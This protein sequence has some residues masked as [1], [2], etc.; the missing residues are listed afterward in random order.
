[1]ARIQSLKSW[2]Q[3]FIGGVSLSQGGGGFQTPEALRWLGRRPP[4]ALTPCPLSRPPHPP[5]RERGSRLERSGCS[6]L[7]S[8]MSLLAFL[9][10]LPGR[11]AGRGREKRAGVMR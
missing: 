1:M 3:D 6:S 8:L 9:P 11:G 2:Y 5:P 10:L 7:L 4:P